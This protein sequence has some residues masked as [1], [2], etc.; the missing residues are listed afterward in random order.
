MLRVSDHRVLSA[1]E[2][3]STTPSKSPGEEW[4]SRSEKRVKN[5]EYRAEQMQ[6]AKTNQQNK[7]NYL[8]NYKL[9]VF[10]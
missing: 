5:W 1:N 2:S 3:I 8:K 7:K 10:L 4:K 9:K 6:K